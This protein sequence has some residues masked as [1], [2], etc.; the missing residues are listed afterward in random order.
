MPGRGNIV[1]VGL[2]TQRDMDALGAGFRN[3]FPID[4]AA[5]FEDL[6][7]AIDRATS[8]AA[9]RSAGEAP[10]VDEKGRP[11]QGSGKIAAKE[12]VVGP[13]TAERLPPRQQ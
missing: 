9:M 2:L 8:T 1:A 12:P 5:D 13:S 4:D 7:Q 3:A 11:L 10:V 6:L